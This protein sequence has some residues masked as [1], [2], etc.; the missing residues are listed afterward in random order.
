[1]QY[2]KQSISMQKKQQHTFATLEKHAV[3]MTL[4]VLASF[5]WHKQKH[6]QVKA[7]TNDTTFM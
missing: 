4:T 5:L 3:V 1:M 7:A 2:N 6:I